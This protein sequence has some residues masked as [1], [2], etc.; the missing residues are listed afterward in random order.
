MKIRH[1]EVQPID[2]QM[3]PADGNGRGPVSVV[4]MV[5]LVLL[6][7][8]SWKCPARWFVLRLSMR[9]SDSHCVGEDLSDLPK[10]FPKGCI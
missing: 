8:F 1:K 10:V 2:G 7:V 6:S 9:K 3:P 4:E 5:A